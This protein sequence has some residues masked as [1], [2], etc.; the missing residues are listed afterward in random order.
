MAASMVTSEGGGGDD[1]FGREPG[2]DSFSV[3]PGRRVEN[4][5]IVK[6]SQGV[7]NAISA[8]QGRA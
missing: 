6:P 1:S 5:I 8:Q 4:T 2:D 7:K 3:K